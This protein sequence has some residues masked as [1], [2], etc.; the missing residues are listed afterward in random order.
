MTRPF[1]PDE[2]LACYRRGVFP[3]AETRHDEGLFL[4]DP[5]WRAV[6]PLTRFHTPRRLARTVRS[7]LFTVTA[8]REFGAV[9][10]ACA[11]SRPGRSETW[12]NP[13]IRSLYTEL[14]HRGAA[15]SIEARI[16][17]RLAGGLYGV[18]LG[19]AFFGESMFSDAR[20]ASKVA[21]VHLAARLIVG[22]FTLLDAQFITEH[23]AQFGAEEISRAVFHEQLSAALQI[24]ADF[25]RIGED[26]R[27][28]QALQVIA[29]IS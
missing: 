12:I 13:A 5:E 20:D 10:D 22:G 24:D 7:D 3:M 2:L 9:L 6:F 15:H 27:G 28:A 8:D 18:A 23:L 19:G 29:Q 16:G 11:R 14:Y 4:V 1:G 17:G 21:L 25:R 26:V